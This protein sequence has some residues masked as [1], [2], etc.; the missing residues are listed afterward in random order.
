MSKYIIYLLSHS[1]RAVSKHMGKSFVLSMDIGKKMLGALWQIE[2][3]LKVDDLC[4]SL[5]DGGVE[6]RQTL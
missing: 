6:L 5:P 1:S 2:N 3:G 4:R